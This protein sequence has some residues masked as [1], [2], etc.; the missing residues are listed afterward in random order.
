MRGV[1]LSEAVRRNVDEKVRRAA[2]TIIGG[3][4]APRPGWSAGLA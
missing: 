1:E 3:K 2:Y 4:G